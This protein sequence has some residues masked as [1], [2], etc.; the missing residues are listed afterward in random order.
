MMIAKYND[1][2]FGRRL[3]AV[4]KYKGMT[5]RELSELI[6]MEDSSLSHYIHGHYIPALPNFIQ[7]AKALN[8][9]TDYLLGLTSGNIENAFRATVLWSDKNG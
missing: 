2:P 8:V 5:Q 1:I 3:N 7:I 9:S 6:H 4:L